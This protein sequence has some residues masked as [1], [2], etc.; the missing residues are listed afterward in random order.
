ME[1][2]VS[3]GGLGPLIQRGL[4]VG[5]LACWWHGCGTGHFV[6]RPGCRLL[7]IAFPWFT[8]DACQ[9][10][11]T[12]A[13]VS[14]LVHLAI[15][16][17]ARAT[18]APYARDL[19]L[20][21]VLVNILVSICRCNAALRTPRDIAL[22][23]Q[24]ALALHQRDAVAVTLLQASCLAS[25]CTLQ[26]KQSVTRRRNGH[27]SAPCGLDCWTAPRHPL[28][29]NNSCCCALSIGRQQER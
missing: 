17:S 12:L 1:I 4:R 6:S 8:I 14:Y 11:A 28:E 13:T 7:P 19:S 3:N 10:R 26:G 9:R 23:A 5:L 18:P 25:I 15:R 22:L 27:R 16:A 21:L 2:S 24:V 29:G 20:E